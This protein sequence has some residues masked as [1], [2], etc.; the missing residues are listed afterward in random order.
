MSGMSGMSDMAPVPTVPVDLVSMAQERRLVAARATCELAELQTT[1]DAARA[2][3]SYGRDWEASI[4]LGVDVMLLMRNLDLRPF[5]RLQQTAQH[6]HFI[7]SVQRRTVP[8]E[9]R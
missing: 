8:R 1:T 6:Q 7:D 5:E 3:P 2:M 4:E 9:L